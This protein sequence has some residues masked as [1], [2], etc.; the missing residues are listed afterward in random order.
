MINSPCINTP[1]HELHIITSHHDSRITTLTSQ[2]PSRNTPQNLNTKAG[3]PF[4]RS[5]RVLKTKGPTA[6]SSADTSH[7]NTNTPIAPSN[8]TVHLSSKVEPI[9]RC[10]GVWLGTV[11]ALIRLWG[12]GPSCRMLSERRTTH[13]EA[14]Y[15]VSQTVALPHFM[16]TID[17]E[18][19]GNGKGGGWGSAMV[20]RH[21]TCWMQASEKVFIL[22]LCT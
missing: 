8:L 22:Q 20:W 12:V 21:I 19:D 4:T 3:T 1:K 13:I 14:I 5:T 9:S 7:Q 10:R 15:S 6:R 17:G 2:R 16:F 11:R 18:M